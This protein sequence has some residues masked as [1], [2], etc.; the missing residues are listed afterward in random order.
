[1]TG[2]TAGTA[3]V[4]TPAAASMPIE[5]GQYG[6]VPNVL[7]KQE[8]VMMFKEEQKPPLGEGRERNIDDPKQ[9]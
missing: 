9:G 1:V 4:T 7:Q 6:C 2:A 8:W 3:A 5:Y